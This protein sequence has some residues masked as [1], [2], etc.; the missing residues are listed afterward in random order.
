MV[1]S[2]VV[3]TLGSAVV[4]N[5]SVVVPVVLTVGTGVVRNIS[6]VEVRVDSPV[7]LVVGNWVVCKLGSRVVET[8]RLFIGF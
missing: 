7:V 1:G 8:L 4:W 5:V 2:R 3:D 6:L